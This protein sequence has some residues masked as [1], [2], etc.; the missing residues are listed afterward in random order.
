MNIIIQIYMIMCVI[1]LVFDIS[2]L[3]VKNIKKMTFY[4]SNSTF[5]RML[6]K[7]IAK[8]EK[9]GEFS[10]SF[11][12]I[13]PK[14]LSR[15]KNL[16]VLQN[17]LEEN[18]HSKDW[19]KPMIFSLVDTYKQK[20]DYDQA[21]Y[22]YVVSQLGYNET[23]PSDFASHF[24]SFLDS[25]SL[26][27]FSNTMDALY[28]FSEINLLIAGIEKVDE[29]DGFYHKKLFVDGLLTVKVDKKV[30][31]EKLL[32]RFN[33]YKLHTKEALLDYFRM[34]DV[35]V[36]EF[37]LNLLKS[38]SEEPE[39]T[40]ACMRYFVKYANDKAKDIFIN[41]LETENVDWVKQML[42]IQGLRKYSDDKT[43]KVI[44][45]KITDRNWYVRLNALE[46][47]FANG[48][49]N[50]RIAEIFE[51]KDKYTLETL[52]YLFK[53]DEEKSALITKT[54]EEIASSQKS[55]EKEG[56]TV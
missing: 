32:E 21:F 8:R 54:L 1:L 52:L 4:K 51:T 20:S 40:Y 47:L 5:E 29:R 23:V 18:P 13:L 2:F 34:I 12:N 35:D 19:F 6:K 17:A 36:S 14:A 38:K 25:K 42:A 24:M 31:T 11:I 33:N 28:A 44:K 50:E 53:N 41:I 39:I 49:D 55:E 7:E 9:D 56:V 30:L 26:Y 22:I 45:L 3:L 15:T 10:L 46:Y 48:L 27:T 16:V 37:C 43:E